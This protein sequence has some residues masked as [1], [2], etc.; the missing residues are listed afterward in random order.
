MITPPYGW[1]VN[2]MLSTS[3]ALNTS[4]C[5][6]YSTPAFHPGIAMRST[7]EKAFQMLAVVSYPE[8]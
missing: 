5:T 4:G 8:A 2:A 1:W 6:T 3:S 7:S